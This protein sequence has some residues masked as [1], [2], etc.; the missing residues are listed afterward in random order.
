MDYK[1]HSF[2]ILL[3]S[4]RELD[5]VIVIGY[6]TQKKSD[7]TGAVTSVGEVELNKGRLSDP[8]QAMQG[9]A[10]GVNVS[11]KGG[12]PNSGFSINIRGAA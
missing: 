1:I 5:E 4:D 7:K 11:K 6:S 12:D 9:K 10:A 3:V 2:N 8:I